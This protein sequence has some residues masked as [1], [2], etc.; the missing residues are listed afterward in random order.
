MIFVFK[1]ISQK[2]ISKVVSGFGRCCKDKIQGC[3]SWY[4][5]LG[6]EVPNRNL[7][8]SLDSLSFSVLEERK[9]YI[10]SELP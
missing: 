2:R 9:V 1:Q 5:S 3:D 7:T 10:H 8:E 6:V 4:V